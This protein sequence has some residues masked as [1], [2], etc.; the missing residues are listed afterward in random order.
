MNQA[1]FTLPKTA[2][3]GTPTRTPSPNLPSQQSPSR[4]GHPQPPLAPPSLSGKRELDPSYE[5]LPEPSPNKGMLIGVAACGVALL[6][7]GLGMIWRGSGTSTPS[8][9]AAQA[10]APGGNFFTEQQKL[11]REAVDMAREAQQM[12]KDRMDLLRKQVEA[13]HE[14]P[15]NIVNPHN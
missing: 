15:M 5:A 14:G 9:P 2:S 13:S 4:P 11:M 12:Q 6:M 7:F 8:T 10:A 1:N 3:G